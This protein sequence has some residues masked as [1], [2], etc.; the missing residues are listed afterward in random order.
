MVQVHEPLS[1]GDITSHL[2]QATDECHCV[3]PWWT[4]TVT[5]EPNPWGIAGYGA[6]TYGESFADVYDDW[7]SGLDD[8]DFIDSIVALV[9]DHPVR[10]LELGVGTGRLVRRWRTKRGPHDDVIVGV[11]SSG[12]MLAVA[13]TRDLGSHTELVL[14]DFS[15]ELPAGPFDAIFV[16]H[17][18]FF[19]LPDHVA[20]SDCFRLVATRLAPD[21][22]L[23]LDVVN[24]TNIPDG[25]S[26]LDMERPDGTIVRAITSHDRDVQRITGRF[27]EMVDGHPIRVREWSVRYATPPQLDAMAADAGL[28]LVSRHSDGRESPFDDQ[29]VRHV[30]RYGTNNR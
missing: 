20:M 25:D 12:S 27:V 2:S 1:V 10:V 15:R 30:S 8:L 21:A 16:G 26:T 19:N 18:T 9:P 22:L 24:P 17:N 6:D 7:Y 3:R 4:W 5:N 28:R 14:G 29:S 13:R 11:D 23:H